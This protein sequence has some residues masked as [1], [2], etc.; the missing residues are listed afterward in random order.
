MT[1]SQTNSQENTFKSKARELLEK[2]KS[3]SPSKP[4]IATIF[5]CFG[6]LI[7]L[8][9]QSFAS[10]T[11]E[12]TLARE[13]EQD[14]QIKMLYHW[15]NEMDEWI[16]NNNQFHREQL[17]HHY[18]PDPFTEVERTHQ[19][20]RE[21]IANF[22]KYF[23][24]L[25]KAENKASQKSY[26]SQREDDNSVYYQLNFSGFDK[27]EISVKIEN[28]ILNLS[29]KKSGNDRNKDKKSDAKLIQNS[30]FFYSFSLPKNIDVNNP[31]ITK[32]DGE[33]IVRFSKKK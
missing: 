11:N 16:K 26:L 20:I 23:Y 17:S 15:Q 6:I 28:N 12:K 9:T 32:K 22:E 14:H 24:E 7:T 5:L 1:K 2:L 8:I 27:E 21:R 25:N 10:K 13:A 33:I 19:R 29:A 30:N 4:F 18:I 31:Q 3:Y